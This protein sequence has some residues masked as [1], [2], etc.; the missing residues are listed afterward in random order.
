MLSDRADDFLELCGGTPE[1]E[2]PDL[3]C[4]APEFVKG[5][6]EIYTPPVE[7][8][9]QLER[10][11]L[12]NLK[13]ALGAAR[14]LGLRLYPL[15]TYPL[16]FEPAMRE[17]PDYEV[18]VRTVGRERFVHAGRCAGTHIHLEL[19]AGT[20]SADAGISAAAPAAARSEALTLYNLATALDPALVALTRSSPFYEGRVPGFSPRTVRY[21]G[22][23]AFGWEGV[24]TDL[25][26]V[27]ALLPYAE[28]VEDLVRQQFDRYE[29]WLAAMDRAGVERGLFVEAGG[30]LL[31]PA[32]NPVRLNRQGTVELRGMDSNYP[33]V[34]LAAA[35]LISGSADRVRREGLEVR[36]EE[37]IRAFELDGGTLFVPDFAYL[38]TDLLYAAVAGDPLGPEVSR[39]LDSILDFAGEG[40]RRL[41]WLR[42]HR[43]STG[44]YPITESALLEHHRL[45]NGHV[46]RREGLLVVQEACDE[47]EAQVDRLSG[48]ADL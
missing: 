33:D 22:G 29:A 20:V 41:S 6:V 18:Q 4:V 47:L 19:P 44:G 7:D 21:R 1:G 3:A 8:L 23:A 31:R 11:Y 45:K 24:Y 9:V 40:T 42:E 16:P 2:G 14:N 36:P 25:P 15:G 28:S 30:D 17:E 37:G 38:G 34:T 46:S 43:R 13:V 5:L 26:Q 39:Y 10:E 32:W 35:T 48:D 27:G 12:R